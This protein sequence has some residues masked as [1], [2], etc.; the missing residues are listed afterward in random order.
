MKHLLAIALGM[1]LL[2]GCGE[3]ASEIGIPV[4][5][6]VMIPIAED[7]EAR[8]IQ[9]G[10]FVFTHSFP[11]PANSLAA[12]VDDD[13]LLVDTPYTPRAT[14]AML[15]WLEAEVGSR[16]TIA[17][18]T[19]W[20]LDNLGGN[21]YLLQEGIPIYGSDLAVEL[22]AERGA[23]SQ[24]QVVD[25]LQDPENERF[26]SFGEIT[27]TSPTETFPLVKGQQL[28]IGGETVE[29]AWPGPGHTADNLVVYFPERQLLF[30]G[31]FIIGGDRIGNTADA[32]LDQWADSF[33]H[34]ARYEFDMVVPGHG[35]RLDPG[36]I[37]H[38]IELLLDAG[39]GE[40][41]VEK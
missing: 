33:R 30:G 6:D 27:L 24:Q 38:T 13:L 31:C 26:R 9:E 12:V 19:H 25:W 41:E 4:D 1:A 2:V 10:L 14:E 8:H 34:I 29:V 35:N 15:N 17:I 7:L 39:Y 3:A 32:H 37:D 16:D 40:I 20:H 28:E 11:W 23:A 5:A 18:N 36:L 21:E 22:L